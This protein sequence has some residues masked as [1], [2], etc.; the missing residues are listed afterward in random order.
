MFQLSAETFVWAGNVFS[1]ACATA[2]QSPIFRIASEAI[3]RSSFSIP[4]NSLRRYLRLGAGLAT[5]GADAGRTAAST[6]YDFSLS[7]P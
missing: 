6:D 3:G 4:A 7:S 5:L 2:E 1:R